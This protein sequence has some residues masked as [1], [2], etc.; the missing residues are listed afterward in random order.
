MA[1]K[2]RQFIYIHQKK[3]FAMQSVIM[4]LKVQITYNPFYD[5]FI[6]MKK[7]KAYYSPCFIL[8]LKMPGPVTGKSEIVYRMEEM[9]KKVR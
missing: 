9:M 5:V 6:N 8:S 4:S 1:G 3:L 7:K 2:S